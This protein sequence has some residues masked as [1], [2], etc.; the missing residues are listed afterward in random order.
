MLVIPKKIN[1]EILLKF[2]ANPCYLNQFY[3]ERDRYRQ[4]LSMY[5]FYQMEF[6]KGQQNY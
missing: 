2:I 3:N 5:Q 1:I 4:E 6:Y